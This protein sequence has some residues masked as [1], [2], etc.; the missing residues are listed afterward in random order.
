MEHVCSTRKAALNLQF[1]IRL[2][3]KM[4]FNK[5]KMLLRVNLH[6]DWSEC[7]KHRQTIAISSNSKNNRIFLLFILCVLSKKTKT[8]RFFQV[9]WTWK[10]IICV[11]STYI[12]WAKGYR[13]LHAH[14]SCFCVCACVI[15]DQFA[16]CVFVSVCKFHLT[17]SIFMV[18]RCMCALVFFCFFTINL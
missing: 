16:E 15:D 9:A 14:F 3:R 18:V 7:A 10:R 8:E 5:T 1:Y 12:W 11:Q 6:I 13:I 17:V 2:K 4:T